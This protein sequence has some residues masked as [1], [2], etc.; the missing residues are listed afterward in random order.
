MFD[1]ARASPRLVRPFETE[2]DAGT[3]WLT[4]LRSRAETGA[5]QAFRLWLQ[6][7][8]EAR[9]GRDRVRLA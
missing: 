1:G 6:Q 8:A 2:I 7:E 9:P 4:R 3:Y 5:M